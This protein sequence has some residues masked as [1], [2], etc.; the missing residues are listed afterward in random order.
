MVGTSNQSDPE[1]P[2]DYSAF[3]QDVLRR[4]RQELAAFEGP[5][6][7]FGQCRTMIS[8]VMPQCHW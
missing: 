4:L 8:M 3:R 5:P 1:I 7:G 6:E 2:I